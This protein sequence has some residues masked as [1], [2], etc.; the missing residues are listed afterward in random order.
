MR[1]H[2]RWTFSSSYVGTSEAEGN[3]HMEAE[4]AEEAEESCRT[5]GGRFPQLP[6]GVLERER[7][8]RGPGPPLAAGSGARVHHPGTSLR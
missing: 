8:A 7:D 6:H 1:P 4:E 5:V 3:P 2:P